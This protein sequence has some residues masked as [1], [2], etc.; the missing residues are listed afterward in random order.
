MSSM[1][2]PPGQRIVMFDRSWSATHIMS[3]RQNKMWRRAITDGSPSNVVLSAA[4]MVVY[5]LA[6]DR[7]V[8]WGSR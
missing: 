5:R 1:V 6:S 7:L 2:E 4:G 8:C 3:T